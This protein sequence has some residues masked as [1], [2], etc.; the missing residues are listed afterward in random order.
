MLVALAR[1]KVAR[2]ANLWVG[3]ACMCFAQQPSTPNENFRISLSVSPF[4]E[5]VFRHG[6][7]F[8]D[9]KTTAQ[10]TYELQKMFN[11]HGANEVYAR[12][13]TKH[14]FTPG[15]GDHS[16][17]LGLDRAV[18]AKA[19]GLPFNPEIGLFKAYGDVR[20][21]PS[22]DFSDYKELKVAGEWTSL[23]L[24]QMLPILRSY[25]TLVAREILETGVK[26]RIWD[27]GNEVE[28]GFAG[29]AVRPGFP[30][31]CDSTEG[32]NWY[33]GPDAID[34]AIGKMGFLQLLKM[35]EA[36]RIRWLETHLWP[37][38]AKMLAAVAEGIRAV[39]P[40][41]RFST[42]V[43]GVISVMPNM[44]I[45]FYKSMRDGGFTPDE[46]GFSFYPTSGDKNS[47]D[48][49]KAFKETATAVQR[50]LKRLVFIA[51]YSYPAEKME[52]GFVWNNAVEGY[53][54]TSEGQAAFTRDLVAWGAQ[55]RVLSG[56][57][58]WAPDLV[59]TPGWG[60]MSFFAING[61][62]ASARPGLDAVADG[63]LS[64]SRSRGW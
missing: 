6:V 26:V 27:I 40:N 9:G 10:T 24:D 42:H 58:P 14:Q 45:A 56:I 29:V 60:P 48:P 28:F 19:L 51:E 41:A 35:S 59:M 30:G 44:S 8:T 36:E 23:T 20:C 17:D 34:P 57:R 43:S 11:A 21:Q 54:L 2:L 52:R 39:D 38:E 1:T 18:L 47:P 61:K 63:L 16:V 37:R 4:T 49:L 32:S 46:L 7:V 33:K 31:A 25:G 53:P 3:M 13:S 5:G 55:S 15:N 50:E 12:I 64:K 22:P 62:T